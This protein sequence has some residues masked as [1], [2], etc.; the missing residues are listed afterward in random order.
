MTQTDF[1]DGTWTAEVQDPTTGERLLLDRSGWV[2]TAN[3]TPNVPSSATLT[4]DAEYV[5]HLRRQPIEWTNELA[6]ARDGLEQW[7]G[8]VTSVGEDE[9]GD[10]VWTAEDRM[11][12]VVY[13][14]IWWHTFRSTA[15]GTDLFELLLDAADYGGPVGLRRDPRPNGLFTT[16]DVVAGDKL[17]P[18]IDQLATVL[19]WVVVGDTVRFGDIN[20]DTGLVLPDEAWGTARPSIESDGYAPLS[21]VV[22]ITDSGARVFYPSADP[23]ERAAGTPF[24]VDTVNLGDVGLAEAG[25]AAERLWKS[26]QRSAFIDLDA[27]VQL[28]P[29]FPLRFDQ[30]VP[31]A[32][33][34]AALAGNGIAAN[35]VRFRVQV[36]EFDI[37]KGEDVEAAASFAEAPETAT[38]APSILVDG[39]RV[40]AGLV[41]QPVL[42]TDTRDLSDPATI[43]ER[44]VDNRPPSFRFPP[45]YVPLT[46]DDVLFPPKKATYDRIREAVFSMPGAVSLDVSGRYVVDLNGRIT[47]VFI[48]LGS[49]GTSPITIQFRKNGAALTPTYQL[50]LGLTPNPF[51]YFNTSIP[52]AFG[53]SIQVETLTA[54]AGAED[55]TVMARIREFPPPKVKTTT[56]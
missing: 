11:A 46:E 6:L 22:G 26:R 32:V 17:Q 15:V 39:V 25:R 43:E 19:E 28:G 8:P 31:G 21:H 55:L 45:T 30:V 41:G 33:M 47:Q 23:F 44:S 53:D 50:P 13:R 9:S 37:A 12:W 16:L 34:S 7:I 10:V 51:R 49:Y 38:P 56:P 4:L 40:P 52:V 18:A 35:D 3:R 48:A 54:D 36:F 42:P 14:R 5:A 29:Q 20:V 24:L 1:G 2:G 27:R